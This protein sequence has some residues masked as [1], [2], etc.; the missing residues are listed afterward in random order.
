MYRSGKRPCQIL[1]FEYICT[2]DSTRVCIRGSARLVFSRRCACSTVMLL[3]GIG[4]QILGS[5]T[6]C[7]WEFCLRL[8]FASSYEHFSHLYTSDPSGHSLSPWIFLQTSFQQ[9]SF[10]L[11]SL[12]LSC[13]SAAFNHFIF[14]RKVTCVNRTNMPPLPLSRWVCFRNCLIRL[15]SCDSISPGS[16]RIP[17]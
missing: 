5:R 14:T 3:L 6:K 2:G 15:S 9:I 12:K 16:V 13:Q 10:H 11:C 7:Q 1:K 4:R 8:S 17:K